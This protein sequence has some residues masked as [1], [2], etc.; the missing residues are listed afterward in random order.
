MDQICIHCKLYSE[1][2]NIQCLGFKNNFF[3]KYHNLFVKC[4]FRTGIIFAVVACYNTTNKQVNTEL[5]PY[6]H[7][8]VENFNI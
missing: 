4:L 2:I 5:I 7:N 8:H 1:T 3:Y 6:C